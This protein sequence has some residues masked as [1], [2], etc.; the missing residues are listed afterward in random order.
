MGSHD[1][2]KGMLSATNLLRWAYAEAGLAAW[3]RRVEDE[4]QDDG[5]AV[6]CVAA[7]APV[8]PPHV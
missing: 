2:S 6:G 5:F 3:L 8:Y 4:C 7:R 1:L